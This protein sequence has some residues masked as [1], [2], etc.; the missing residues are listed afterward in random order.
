MALRLT[1]AVL[2]LLLIAAGAFAAWAWRGE[3]PPVDPPARSVFDPSTITRGRAL[4]A[5]GDCAACHTAPG[6]KAYAGGLPIRT[7]FGT[8][9]GTNITPD[10]T[11]GIGRWSLAAFTRALR[12]GVARDGRHLYPAFPYDH[13]RLATDEDIQ[14]IYAYLMT[15]E[16]VHAPT[17]ENRMRFPLQFRTLVAGWKLFF[18]DRMSYQQDPAQSVEWNRGAYLVQGL[19]HCG[20]CHTPRNIAGAEKKRAFLAGSQ[21]EGWIAPSLNS[22]SRTPVPWTRDSLYDYLRTGFHENHEVAAG[23]MAPVVQNLARAP[24]EDVRA[25]AT[26][27][28]SLMGPAGSER[29]RLAQAT[30]QRVAAEASLLPGEAPPSRASTRAD[31]NRDFQAGAQIYE[32][33]CALCHGSR[34]QTTAAGDALHLA[35]STSLVLPEPTNLV[36]IILQGMA[37]PDGERGPM[38]PGF[39]AA[40]TDE[41]VVALVEFLRAQYTQRPAWRNIERQVRKVRA[42]F[43]QA[44]HQ[45]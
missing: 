40:L 24:E 43:A 14:A 28:S 44:G 33:T 30:L 21:I 11:T 35:L 3:L 29:E 9:Y 20:A 42:S 41:Q 17:P 18:L 2:L 6:G 1:L 8:I 4:A 45:P 31:G 16:P 15:R 13:F 7:Q 37:P 26:Y 19:A 25:I 23:P 10:A 32:G 38:M 12:E 36:R 5:I 27:I 39:A 34:V 22:T